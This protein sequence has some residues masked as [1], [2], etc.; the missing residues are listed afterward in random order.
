MASVWIKPRVCVSGMRYIVRYRLGG[1]Q[2]RVIHAAS[3][4]SLDD[5]NRL[6]EQIRAQIADVTIV[7]S[8]VSSVD[9]R[10]PR[11]EFVYFATLGGLVKIGISVDP[12]RR[13]RNLNATLVHTEP[14]GRQRER[15]LHDAF[16][17]ARVRGEWFRL[18]ARI[19]RYLRK[20][21]QSVA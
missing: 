4:R 18:D 16:K 9:P 21:E 19:S 12:A 20:Q 8:P 7:S 2:S 1:R 6:V 13:A 17:L 3:L 15:E 11:E 14:G 10:L 5:A